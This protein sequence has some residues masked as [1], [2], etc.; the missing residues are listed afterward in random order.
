MRSLPF[1]ETDFDHLA[2]Q[3]EES[4]REIGR[5]IS[6]A[7]AASPELGAEERLTCSAEALTRV[8]EHAAA[9]Q[10]RHSAHLNQA[11]VTQRRIAELFDLSTNTV[12][13][14]CQDGVRSQIPD[15]RA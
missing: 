4:L 1:D 6:D 7:L 14:W 9:S 5:A 2:S 12:N 8:K 10:R 15:R 3:I 13:R 11:G